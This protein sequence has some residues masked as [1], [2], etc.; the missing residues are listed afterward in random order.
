MSVEHRLIPDAQL[1]EPKGVAGAGNK[2]IYVATG[3][4]TGA[5]R[6]LTESDLSYTTAANNIR[7]W[8]DIADS[9]YTLG[10]PRAVGSATRTLLTNNALAGQTNTTR[11]GS[12]WNTGTS[13]F[14]IND[15]NAA[16]LFR[17]S[18]KVKAAAAAG[19]PYVVK[20]EYQSDNGP[21]VILAHDMVIKGGGYENDVTFTDLLYSGSFINNQALALYVT[22]DTA[23]TLY[24]V[25]FV[26][27]RVYKET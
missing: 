23:I 16:Y 6:K 7:G 2:E 1:H 27:E 5:W 9:Q 17:V 12:I 21:T 14:L 20:L 18:M 15:L 19:T 24:N 26:V 13:K 4:G 11:L 22:A 8:N 3:T 10:S 25:G